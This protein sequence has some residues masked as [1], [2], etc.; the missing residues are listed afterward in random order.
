M[1]AR[2][3]VLALL[4]TVTVLCSASELL[5]Q[6][7]KNVLMLNEVGQSHPGSVLVTNRILAAI[8]SD[9]NIDA[10]LHWENMDAIDM[11]DESRNEMRD[12]ILV[13]YHDHK[14]DLILL[15]GPD[16][17]RLMTDPSRDFYPGV[18]VV[19]CCSVLGK[20]GR[21]NID[22]RTTG[23]WLQFDPSKTVDSALRLLPETRQVYVVAGQSRYDLDAMALVKA[24]LI[25][26]ESRLAF[27]YLTDLPTHD[28]QERLKHLPSRSIVLYVSF[29][30]DVNGR[31][32]LNATE[33]LPLVAAASNAPVFGLSDTYL[34]LG[35]VGGYVVSFDEQGKI[36]A[37]DVIEILAGKSPRDIPVVQGP[38]LYMFDWRQ[39][40]RWGLDL[41]KLPAGSIVLYRPPS[42]WEQHRW[43]VLSTS[44]ILVILGLLAIY[45]QFT[46]RQLKLSRVAQS[47]LSSILINA[48][49][50]ER[51]RLAGEIHDDFSQRL[52]VI[53]LGLE[54]AADSI[55]QAPR[56]AC[57]KLHQLSDAVSE[58]GGDLHTLS[59]RLHSATLDSLGLAAAVRSFCDEFSAQHRIKVDALLES[60]PP[61]IPPDV[62]LCAFR[63]VQEGL[64]NVQKHSGASAAKVRMRWSENTLHLS[65]SDRGIG[66]NL[67]E[68]NVNGGIGIRSMQERV[69]HLGGRFEIRSTT[70]TGTTIDVQLPLQQKPVPMDG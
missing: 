43:T 56:E 37:R 11:S 60:I 67:R 21:E 6:A 8:R 55:S 50:E 41:R 59:H 3:Q 61:S 65:V 63:A 33:A 39:L 40:R 16:P 30:K 5:G 18:P 7:K 52:A 57:R 23:T 19:F 36:A 49:E 2:K 70:G 66:F 44:L 22:S 53:S 47:Q 46:G 24:A 68:R 10:D 28:L 17:I 14:W 42:L 54:S 62:S 12:S 38:S 48:Q 4:V 32:L 27:S 29:H 1:A 25:P 34:G 58:I 9:Q 31:A 69:R 51:K 15:M 45:L 35:A 26:Y 20:G 64:R 13:K